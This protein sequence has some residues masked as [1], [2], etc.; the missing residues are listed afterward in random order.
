MKNNPNFT[1]P[2]LPF[3]DGYV[4]SDYNSVYRSIYNKEK[5]LND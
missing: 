2:V 3:S 1:E 4:I 5:Y